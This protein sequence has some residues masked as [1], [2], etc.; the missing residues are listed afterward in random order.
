MKQR[1]SFHLFGRRSDQR[2][3]VEVETAIVLPA[4]VFLLLRLFAE[5]A[6]YKAVRTGAL[7]NM[8]P[9]AMRLAA[10]AAALP[11]LAYGMDDNQNLGRADSTSAWAEKMLKIEASNALG[12]SDDPF[13]RDK[14][15]LSYINLTI[16][17]PTRSEVSAAE[18]TAG[19][20]TY[21]SFDSDKLSGEMP[22]PKLRIEIILNYRLVIPF[23]DAV[24]YRM[25]KGRGLAESL[26]L[27]SRTE[28]EKNA[29]ELQNVDEYDTQA[30]IPLR[31]FIIPIRAQYAMRLQ[32]DVKVD[33][34]P[35]S[36]ECT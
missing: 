32:S 30:A 22:G 34:L 10:R 15:P 29:A 27:D 9:D 26:R 19:G 21:I 36:N 33:R 20:D 24:I 3:Q 23:A 8:E 12:G 18:Y 31:I 16:C 25:W 28:I 4:V 6:A 7:K 35:D 1:K 17:G 13:T 14:K 2:G 11:I 5:Y